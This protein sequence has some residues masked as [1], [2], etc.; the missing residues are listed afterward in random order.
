MSITDDQFSLCC[1][2][3]KSFPSMHSLHT[4]VNVSHGVKS[5]ERSSSSPVSRKKV[6]GSGN[7]KAHR[8]SVHAIL[9]LFCSAFTH[10]NISIVSI[11]GLKAFV[12]EYCDKS[13]TQKHSLKKH[14]STAHQRQPMKEANTKGV[15]VRIPC[16]QSHSTLSPTPSIEYVSK[17][18]RKLLLDSPIS[19]E[20]TDSPSGTAD[21][22]SSEV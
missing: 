13:Y 3:G 14:I 17:T 10:W 19:R 11:L 16:L 1:L 5:D 20:S 15:W 2:C 18:K 22:V 7:T 21:T 8:D 12:C 9:H 6:S 4:H